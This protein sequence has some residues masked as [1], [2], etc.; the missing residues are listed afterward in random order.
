MV[1]FWSLDFL[2]FVWSIFVSVNF[3]LHLFDIVPSFA[4]DLGNERVCKCYDS[5]SQ[6]QMAMM[7]SNSHVEGSSGGL[8]TK[9]G[10]VCPALKFKQRKVSAVRY[11]PLGCGR[12]AVLI[13]RPSV[14]ATID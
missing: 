9:N 13:T 10:F 12:V 14:Q 1:R 3:Y 8:P 11:F 4:G 6:K 5:M 2:F 7:A